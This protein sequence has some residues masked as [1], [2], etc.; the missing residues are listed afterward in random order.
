M[1]L[2]GLAPLMFAALERRQLN[3]R[4][5]RLAKWLVKCTLMKGENWLYAPTLEFIG[6]P[7]GFNKSAV[8]DIF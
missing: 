7:L 1:G 3:G 5:L 8:E 6:G 4:P 2:R